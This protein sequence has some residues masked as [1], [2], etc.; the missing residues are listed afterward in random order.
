MGGNLQSCVGT[1]FIS[2]LELDLQSSIRQG[3]VEKGTDKLSIKGL[4]VHPA[5]THSDVYNNGMQHSVQLLTS[6]IQW[7][8][9]DEATDPR[10]DNMFALI[11]SV[12]K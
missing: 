10:L 9:Q 7:C 11:D 3:V 12:S 8:R 2:G 5:R 6:V 4:Y 1:F